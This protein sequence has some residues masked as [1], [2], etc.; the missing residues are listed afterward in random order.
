MQISFFIS[1]C[2]LAVT[3]ADA[4]V[5]LKVLDNI[6]DEVERIQ[7]SEQRKLIKSYYESDDKLK[8]IPGWNEKFKAFYEELAQFNANSVICFEAL[9]GTTSAQKLKD[10]CREFE[11][12]HPCNYT[13]TIADHLVSLPRDAASVKEIRKAIGLAIKRSEKICSSEKEVRAAI[14]ENCKVKTLSE[15][16]KCGL[17]V[18]DNR[19]DA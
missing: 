16:I 17:D 2:F 19:I 7:N 10:A 1:A 5:S 13:E 6:N 15:V 11:G 12:E 14:K 9:D 18:I 8:T 4:D 3:N